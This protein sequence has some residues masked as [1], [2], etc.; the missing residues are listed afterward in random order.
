[1]VGGSARLCRSHASALRASARPRRGAGGGHGRLEAHEQELE[2][3]SLQGPGEGGVAEDVRARRGA[4]GEVAAEAEEG[5]VVRAKAVEPALE[6]ELA[7]LPAEQRAHVGV[8]RGPIHGDGH[9]PG[10]ARR[11]VVELLAAEADDHVARGHRTPLDAGRSAVADRHQEGHRA[12]RGVADPED[13]E[14]PILHAD[15]QARGLDADVAAAQPAGSE[16]R[17]A[18]VSA[19]RGLHLLGRRGD[20]VDDAGRRQ[21]RRPPADEGS[22]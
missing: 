14:R 10:P 13:A 1:M 12:P 4:A 3:P 16:L 5:P 7:Q 9:E 20:D 21:Q 8:E 11:A 2:D 19:R 22:E 17:V 15:P 6:T 18:H